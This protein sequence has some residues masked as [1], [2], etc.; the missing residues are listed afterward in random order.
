MWR[1]ALAIVLWT[2]GNFNHKYFTRGSNWLYFQ[3]QS[4]LLYSQVAIITA[5]QIPLHIS[6]AILADGSDIFS[7]LLRYMGIAFAVWSVFILVGSALVQKLLPSNAYK[8]QY[9]LVFLSFVSSFGEQ[10]VGL[11]TQEID[12]LYAQRFGLLFYLLMVCTIFFQW[13][14]FLTGFLLA[15]FGGN[16]IIIRIHGSKNIPE[17][18]EIFKFVIPRYLK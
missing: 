13:S 14:T 3:F 1:C 18:S 17:V 7:F 16:V 8:L 6:I 4:K 11:Y 2:P 15:F 10:A 5:M 9:I 12:F